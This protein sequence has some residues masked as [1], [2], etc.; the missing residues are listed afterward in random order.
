MECKVHS[1]ML[2]VKVE[3]HAMEGNFGF[4]DMEEGI[5]RGRNGDK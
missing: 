3:P 5:K 4:V 2:F 1:S